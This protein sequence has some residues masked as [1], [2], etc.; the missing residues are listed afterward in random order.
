V[1]PILGRTLE[2][3]DDNAK[4]S[5]PVVVFSYEFWQRKLSGDAN[6]VGQTVRLNQYPYTVIG[7]AAPGF[8]GDTVGDKQDFW[9]PMTMQAQMMPGRAWLEE[10]HASW[11]RSMARLKP[12]IAMGQAEANLNLVFQQWLQGPVGRALD[13][14]D[15]DFLKKAKVPVVPGGKGFSSLRDDYFMPLLLLM[16]F[17]ALVL[18]IACFNVANLLLARASARQKEVA[19]RLAIGAT[20]MRLLR[21]LLTESLLL[22]FA[23]GVLGLLVARWGTESLLKLS[24]GQRASEG[25]ETSPDLHVLLFTAGVCLLTGVVFGL[26]PALRSSRVAVAPTLKESTLAQPRA[27]R[28][29]IGK[30]LVVGEVAICL[31]TLFAA[32]LLVRSLGNLRNVNLGYNKEEILIVRADPVASGYKPAQL[33]NYQEEMIRRLSQLPGVLGVSG[34]ENGLFSG[35]ESADGMK[36]E[37]YVAARDQDRICFWDQV[38]T[39][40]FS[41]LGIPII[42]GRDFGPQD[43]PTSQ[44]VAIINETMSNFYFPGSNPIG[45]KIWID[46]EEHKNQ[47]I[48]IIGVARNVRDHQLRKPVQRR[49]YIPVGQALD[50]LFAINFEIRTTGKP[51]AL[52][53]AVRKTF[54]GFDPNV[55]LT[56]VSTVEELVERSITESILIARLTTVFGLLALLLAC[57]GLYGVMAYAVAGRTREIGVRM[58][59][60]AQRSQVLGMILREGLKLVLIGILVGIPVALLVARLAASMLFGLSPADPVSMLIVIVVLAGIAT[61]AGLLP[62]RRAT[63]VDPMIALRYE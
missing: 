37:G 51:A 1:N 10:V 20:R 12:G 63:K 15:Q 60:G 58:A 56:R 39:T 11:L 35:T 55:P 22:A 40:Y 24:I 25:I 6:I 48:E 57:I 43:T 33:I 54:A 59:L 38:G 50:P 17:V 42:A 19:V 28:F 47:P 13:P 8:F 14:G 26:V 27:G 46:D 45:R 49:F 3:G 16:I 4:A 41:A 23:G 18:L 5:H 52:T 29:P 21:Q 31:L 53:E 2:P 32:G 9:V 44:K 36:I 30:L 61:I 34:S 62:A 7:I